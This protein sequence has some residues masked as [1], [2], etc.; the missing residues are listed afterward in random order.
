MKF[1]FFSFSLALTVPIVASELLYKFPATNND[2]L[3]HGL[4][5]KGLT[6]VSAT[7]TLDELTYTL[8]QNL[9]DGDPLWATDTKHESH[10][11]FVGQGGFC[12]GGTYLMPSKHNYM[13]A[14]VEISIQ[15]EPSGSEAQICYFAET[16]RRDGGWG[17][18]PDF[19]FVKNYQWDV[20]RVTEIL[21]GANSNLGQSKIFC[22]TFHFT[23]RATLKLHL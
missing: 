17:Q 22:R 20:N 2:D 16:V 15:G 8:V 6:S 21:H 19:D 23:K 11:L 12:E 13:P 3:V 1:L 18:L 5:T 9:K 4:C 7:S 14:G 10:S